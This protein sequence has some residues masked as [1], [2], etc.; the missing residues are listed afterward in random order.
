MFLRKNV[1]DYILEAIK[2]EFKVLKEYKMNIYM[3]ILTSISYIISQIIVLFTINNYFNDLLGWELKE[4][5]G[6]L[7][8]TNTFS[9]LA[10]IFYYNR[11]LKNI[12]L[13]GEMNMYLLRPIPNFIMYKM[14][15][16]IFFMFIEFLIE[17]ICLIVFLIYYSNFINFLNF[18][19][20]I[21]F[22]SCGVLFEIFVGN[23]IDS[24]AFFI[25]SNE[26]II[27]LHSQFRHTYYRFPASM[28]R[29]ILFTISLFISVTYVGIFAISFLF[30]NM[31]YSLFF[32]F[33]SLLIFLVIF[34]IGVLCLQ[35]HF[36]LKKYEAYG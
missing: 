1:K 17:I 9:T 36:G 27:S 14:S 21:L 6:F 34:C 15:T 19:L 18:I 26:F 2:V 35:W 12:L 11:I 7:I 33:F 3:G 22:V 10:G 20:I 16:S 8:F 29:G 23:I 4:Y 13:T 24:L 28:F 31:E 25:K 32:K 30:G 5:L